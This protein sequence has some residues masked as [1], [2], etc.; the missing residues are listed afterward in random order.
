MG[1]EMCIRD[2]CYTVKGLSEGIA[3]TAVSSGILTLYAAVCGIRRKN[4]KAE[5]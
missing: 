3:I 5:A 4:G 1:S 2:R